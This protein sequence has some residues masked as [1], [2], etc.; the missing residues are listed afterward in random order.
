M[1]IDKQTYVDYCPVDDGMYDAVVMVE[2][3]TFQGSKYHKDGDPAVRFFFTLAGVTNEETG[4]SAC[5]ASF[6]QKPSLDEKANFFK[7]SKAILGREPESGFDSEELN[8][9]RCQVIVENKIDGDKI[10][11]N[12]TNVV[13]GRK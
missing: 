7:W 10:Y 4:E 6:P 2:D 11:P 8:G 3:T 9:G 12:V 13:P 1:K 5:L